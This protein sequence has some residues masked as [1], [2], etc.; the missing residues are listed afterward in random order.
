[1]P[2]LP[3][4]TVAPA[5]GMTRLS[6]E[7]LA[8]LDA[9]LRAEDADWRRT[10]RETLFQLAHPGQGSWEER[11]ADTSLPMASRLA[12]EAFDP[13]NIT[14][15]PEYYADVDP[16]RFARVKPLLWL[17]YTFDRLPIGGQ[18][19][20][21]GVM[22][23]RVLAPHVFKRVGAN[24]KCFQHVEVSFGYNLEVGDDVVVHRHVLLDDRGGLVL[25]NR[26]SISDYANIYSHT[27]SIVDQQDVTCLRTVLED[28]VRVTYHATVLAGVRVARNGM[29]GAA[30][31]A[32]KDVRPYHVNVGI[33]AKSVRVKPN[34]PPE[35]VRNARL[36]EHP[37]GS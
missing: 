16:E 12:L 14:L 33:P 22:L 35:L 10:C 24:F 7:W 17:W 32:T 15:E 11:V 34:A 6:E 21:L 9:A 1:M 25:G 4:R 23:R 28:D 30:A 8:D 13:A 29:V 37:D 19:V 2:V 31:V 3:L 36:P 27:H 18:H 20:A 5:A 26:V